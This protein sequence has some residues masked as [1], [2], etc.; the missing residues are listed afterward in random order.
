MDTKSDIFYLCNAQGE[1]LAV[2]L[3]I[4]VWTQIEAKVMPLVQEALG[5][6]AEPEEESLPPE[7][8]ADWQTLIDYWDFKYPVNTEVHCDV[9]A[10]RTEDWTK[11]EPRKFWLRAC[12]LGGLLRY[13]C[14]NCQ[15]M[16]TKRLYKDKIKFEATPTQEKDPLLNAVYGHGSAGK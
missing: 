2:Q 4:Q 10:S 5:K 13:R 7:P 8:M 14:L 16:V 15:A 11:D 9:C 12:N 3:P 1:V 6:S